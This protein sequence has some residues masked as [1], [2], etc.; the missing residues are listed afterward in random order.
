MKGLLKVISQHL[1]QI[2]VHIMS[3]QNIT[4]SAKLRFLNPAWTKQKKS[5]QQ[6]DRKYD[7]GQRRDKHV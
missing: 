6:Y 1:N 7:L 4:D 2:W 3:C 5:V